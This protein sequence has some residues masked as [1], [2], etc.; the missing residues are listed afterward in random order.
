MKEARRKKK[1][2]ENTLLIV[3]VPAG[4]QLSC[5]PAKCTLD[6]TKHMFCVFPSCPKAVVEMV[7]LLMMNS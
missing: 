5:Y 6:I 7:M 2:I 1:K 3:E 4:S